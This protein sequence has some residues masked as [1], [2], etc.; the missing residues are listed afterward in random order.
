MKTKLA[1]FV[2]ALTLFGCKGLN[3]FY[4]HNRLQRVA[5]PKYE[6]DTLQISNYILCSY[7]REMTLFEANY[8][9]TR[10]NEDSI[11]SLFS[12]KIE[13][14]GVKNMLN[15][16]SNLADSGLCH[17]EQLKIK[18]IKKRIPEQL[19]F[20]SDSNQTFIIP[21]FQI[22]DIYRFTGY[23]TSNFVAGNDG[24]MNFTSVSLI[25][26]VVKN[27]EIIYSDHRRYASKRTMAPTL[28]EVKAI[29]A[30]YQVREEH[31]EELVRRAMRRYV[32]RLKK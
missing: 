15:F 24:Y 10:F 31:I 9:D 32:R 2:L 26:F 7:Q 28:E 29:P 19:D 16:G 23:L 20:N 25:V 6:D 14:L 27:G 13:K 1:M 30:A 11:M 8:A 22:S 18:H 21:F 4:T 17:R 12:S 3:S 5:M